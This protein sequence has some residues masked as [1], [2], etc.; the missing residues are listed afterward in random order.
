MANKKLL[1]KI[2]AVIAVVI[3]ILLAVPFLIPSDYLKPKLIAQVQAMTGKKLAINGS[4]RFFFLPSLGVHAE[5]VVLSNPA[6]EGLPEEQVAALRS[7]D[8][9]LNAAAFLHGDVA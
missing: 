7:L 1:K 2:G 4:L 8:V 9:R 3:L 5:G 6:M